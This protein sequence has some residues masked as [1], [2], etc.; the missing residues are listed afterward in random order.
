MVRHKCVFGTQDS[1]MTHWV[2]LEVHR[3]P[4]PSP[5][6]NARSLKTVHRGNYPKKI[7][8]L[9]QVSPMMLSQWHED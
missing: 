8:S 5:E 7:V 3:R 1:K 4:I 9:T 6:S 2:P